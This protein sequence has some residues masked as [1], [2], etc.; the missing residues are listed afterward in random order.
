MHEL[1]AYYITYYPAKWA[2]HTARFLEMGF[3]VIVPDLV[4]VS[5]ATSLKVL[6]P[7]LNSSTETSTV[8]RQGPMSTCTLHLI[9]RMAYTLYLRTSRVG[10]NPFVKRSSLV[11]V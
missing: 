3:R 4:A 9:L 8:A 1:Q 7:G 6:H 11:L 5:I 2:P 10:A